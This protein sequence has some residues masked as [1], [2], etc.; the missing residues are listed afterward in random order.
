MKQIFRYLPLLNFFYNMRIYL[1]LIIFLFCFPLSS[2]GINIIAVYF[3]NCQRETGIILNVDESRIQMLTLSG[4]IKDITRYDM[5]YLAYYPIGKIPIEKVTNANAVP[6]IRINTLYQGEIVELVQGW[7]VDLSDDKLSFLTTKGYE[8]VI[9]LD[10]IW[11]V[12]F[13]SPPRVFN[14][15]KFSGTHATAIQFLHP[16]PF[17]H[18]PYQEKETESGKKPQ[19]IFPQQLL[20]DPIIIKKEMDRLMEGHEQIKDY[21]Q[22]QRFYPIPQVYSND[23]SLGLW[24]S[25]GSRYGASKNR[26]NNFTPALINELT[27]GPFG[28]QRVLITGSAPM[29]YSLHE[30]PQI[31]FYYRLKADYVHFSF[32]YD[33]S[34][35]LIG[36]KHYKWGATE[37]SAYDDR[38][39]EIS[40]IGGGFDYGKF[41]V[42]YSIPSIQYAIRH[43]DMFFRNRTQMDRFG[44][45]YRSRSFNL[46]LYYS[47]RNDRKED[48]IQFSD[49]DTEAERAEKE[50]LMEA[51]AKQPEFLTKV[52]VAR[53]NWGMYT[54]SRTLPTYSFI[55]RTID[56][57]QDKGNHKNREFYHSSVS[58]T[59]AFY[60]RYKLDNDFSLIGFFS[61][62]SL[63]TQ[64]GKT[65]LEDETTNFFPK[66]G[67][68]FSLTF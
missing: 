45:F 4:K 54:M 43:D 56:F 27:E 48:D 36:E 8:T 18:C 22:D 5:I 25:F 10:S 68:N 42:D 40:H 34:R 6:I 3:A 21:H 35:F 30:E 9:D 51:L 63:S 46:E 11:E 39:T 24:L 66:G 31:Q 26:S 52:R 55:Y 29:P 57:Y 2:W 38:I 65:G 14:E 67:V 32:M 61:V 62:E 41:A 17:S 28:F 37:L 64:Y 44:V 58:I 13:Y 16:Y 49:D 19:I 59:N 7:L 1:F 50:A 53:L 15:I 20:G 23:I 60:F 12:E 47:L 33:I